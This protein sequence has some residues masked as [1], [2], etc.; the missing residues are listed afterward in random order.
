MPEANLLDVAHEASPYE[1]VVCV[2]LFQPAERAGTGAKHLP[3]WSLVAVT[4]SKVH[5]FAVRSIVPYV[6]VSHPRQFATL[7]RATTVA[8]TIDTVLV[9]TDVDT[10]RE[11][12]FDCS[13]GQC[14]YVL[15]ELQAQTAES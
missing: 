5:I 14:E 11:Y 10:Q 12:R 9:L 2:G 15:Q 3:Q 1:D 6:T 7:D 4:E 13:I 8:R